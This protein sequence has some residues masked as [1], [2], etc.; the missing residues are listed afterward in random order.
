MRI[1]ALVAVVA[2]VAR[3]HAKLFTIEVP[4][5]FG[6]G[7]AFQRLIACGEITERGIALLAYCCPATPVPAG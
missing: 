1:S 4:F 2:A 3:G 5:V 6:A 7:S